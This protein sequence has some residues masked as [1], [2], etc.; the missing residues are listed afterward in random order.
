[1][2]LTTSIITSSEAFLLT[3][4]TYQI[5]DENGQIWHIAR[6]KFESLFERGSSAGFGDRQNGRKSGKEEK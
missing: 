5:K 4:D 1:M 3:K 2:Y 6:E